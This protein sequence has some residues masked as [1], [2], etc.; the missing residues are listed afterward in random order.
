MSANAGTSKKSGNG[1]KAAADANENE[2]T[3]DNANAS[4]NENTN[5]TNTNGSSNA[6]A[7]A[8]SNA[9]AN[10]NENGNAN[11]NANE[12]SDAS[13]DDT[14]DASSKATSDDDAILNPNAPMSEKVATYGDTPYFTA[15]YENSTYTI[16]ATDAFLKLVSDDTAHEYAWDAY[17][18]CER[19][20]VTERHENVF[21]E[22]FN[23]NTQRSNVVW[24]KTPEN[25]SIKL[26]KYDIKS[27][28]KDGDRNSKS[29]SLTV[30]GDTEIGFLITNNGDVPLTNV[31]LTDKTVD[32]TGEVKDIKFPSGWDGTLDPGESVTA[33]GTLTGV[34]AGTSHTDTATVTGKSYYTGKEVT[35][36]DDWNGQKPAPIV[37]TGDASAAVAVA[38]AV[39]TLVA[40]GMIAWRRR[41][42]A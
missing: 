37:Q 2:N 5:T 13:S 16:K 17:I 21:D 8:A 24:T 28:L 30:D 32:G 15:T 6:N 20:W 10:A 41:Q 3:A 29:D 23:S 4:T 27:G 34:K 18:Q 38:G 12:S 25:P 1:S 11:A 7:N 14:A 22:T 42:A 33:T 31:T 26:E 39:V 40:A 35:A 36:K 9:N 19:T